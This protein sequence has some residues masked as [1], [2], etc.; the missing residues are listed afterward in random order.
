[1]KALAFFFL[2]SQ[3]EGRNGCLNYC[4]DLKVNLGEKKAVVLLFNNY[5]F[6][7]ADL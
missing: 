7:K 1:M 6:I 3:I 2:S 5:V 4:V